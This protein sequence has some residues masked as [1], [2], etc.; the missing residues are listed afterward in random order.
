MAR[1]YDSLIIG[2]G[3]AGLSTALGLGRVHRTCAIFSNSTYRNAGIHAAHAILGHDGKSPE[4]IRNAGRKEIEAYG[5]AEF[6]EATIV[7]VSRS[8]TSNGLHS[9]FS[10]SDSVGREWRG[11]TVIL[12]TGV[13]DVFPDLPGYREN[14]PQNIYQCLFCDGH[15]RYQQLKAVLCYP[16]VNLMS[17]KMATMAH[18]QSYP[19]GSK[20]TPSSG[21]SLV[22]V[23][24]NGP[25]NPEKD[26][27][28]SNALKV[29]SAYG[30]EVDERPVS[31]L[32]ADPKQGVHVHFETQESLHF[33]WIFHKPTTELSSTTAS[34]VDQLELAT[35]TTP[36]GTTIKT[37]PPMNSTSVPGLF[38]V[39]DAGNMMTHVTTAIS[40]GLGASGGVS[41][42]CNEWDDADV[43]LQIE[44]QKKE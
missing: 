18:F 26:K 27:S 43:L 39:G 19:P 13:K 20:G 2:S 5:H 7:K 29:L 40:S 28:I 12:A 36:Y 42:F 22:R 1:L 34:F 11:R 10:V 25:A 23:L 9:I 35:A 31:K 33:G 37:E 16:N 6:V 4:E 30:I 41:H 44:G 15:E 14:W 8:Q 21:K 17:I 3:P 38:V 24:T 32:V